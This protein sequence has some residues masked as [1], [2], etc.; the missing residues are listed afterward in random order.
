MT[1]RSLFVALAALALVAW[2][3][4]YLRQGRHN[5]HEGTVVVSAGKLIMTGK[6]GKE[7]THDI[8]A[9]TSVTLNGKEAKL[10]DL[11]KGDKVKVTMGADKKVTEIRGPPE[12]TPRPSPD[13]GRP[14]VPARG[15]HRVCVFR[16]PLRRTTSC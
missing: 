13:L 1:R 10:T 15:R 4:S 16:P 14:G 11:K 7:H 5:T 9:T 3:G 8:G 6:D 2:V 12:L